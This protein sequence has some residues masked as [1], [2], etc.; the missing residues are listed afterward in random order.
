MKADKVDIEKLLKDEP[1]VC[2]FCDKKDA[3]VV[4]RNQV[5]FHVSLCCKKVVWHCKEH[6]WDAARQIVNQCFEEIPLDE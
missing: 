3:E 1:A 5:R 4:D 2:K 6:Q